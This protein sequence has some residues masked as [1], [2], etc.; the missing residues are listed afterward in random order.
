M[1]KTDADIA[2]GQEV[3]ID[4]YRRHRDVVAEFRAVLRRLQ[5]RGTHSARRHLTSRG[6]VERDLTEFRKLQDVVLQDAVL[7]PWLQIG[8]F[9]VARQR[10]ENLDVRVDVEP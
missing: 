1:E 2:G 8:V 10:L 6:V 5:F 9:E 3:I 4:G 7:L